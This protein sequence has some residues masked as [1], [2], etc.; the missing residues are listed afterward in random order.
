MEKY[1]L[2]TKWIFAKGVETSGRWVT[3]TKTH[4]DYVYHA[5]RAFGGAVAKPPK[6]PKTVIIKAP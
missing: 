2:D 4:A 5:M 1:V 6:K 3:M